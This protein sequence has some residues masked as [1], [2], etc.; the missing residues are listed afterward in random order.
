MTQAECSQ[1]ERAELGRHEFMQL[2]H[3]FLGWRSEGLRVGTGNAR[4]NW[5]GW[6]SALVILI[7]IFVFNYS[8]DKCVA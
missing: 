5:D 4:D 3:R 7:A 8:E 1:A 6:G 2:H